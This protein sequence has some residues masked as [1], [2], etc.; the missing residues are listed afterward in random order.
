MALI[1]ADAFASSWD[2]SA[3]ALLM[4]Q[5]GVAVSVEPDGFIMI[6]VV[7]DEAEILTLAVRRAARRRGVGA[8]LIARAATAAYRAGALRLFLEVAEDNASA[9]GLYDAQGFQEVGRRRGYYPRSEGPAVDALIL[10]LNLQAP[11]P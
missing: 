9:R 4:A 3:I 11:L 8:R 7:A 6:R 1:H 5:P 10:S 2:A